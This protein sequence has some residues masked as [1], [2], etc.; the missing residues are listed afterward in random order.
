MEPSLT[1]HY[2]MLLGLDDSWKVSEVKLEM[3]VKRVAIRLEHAG[4]PL[5]CPE[6]GAACTRADLAPERTW[7]HLDTMQ[8]ETVLTARVP[9]SDCKACGVKTCAVPWA[10]KHSPFT[11]LF[12]VF[13]LSVIEASRCIEAARA[14]LRLSWDATHKIMKRGVERGLAHR[15]LSTVKR[16]GIDEKSFLRGQNYIASLC[17]LE[18]ARVIEVVQGRKEEDARRLLTSLP[19]ATRDRI[20]AIAM[21]MWP[22]FI[23]AAGKELP[24]AE[25]VFDRFHVSKHMGEAVDQVR[26]GE[27][28]ELLQ[29]GDKSLAK[30][31]YDW[32]RQEANIA[33]DRRKAFDA[34]K[35]S[36]LKTARAWAIKELLREFWE[37]RNAAFAELHFSKWYAWAVRC[38]LAA[39]KKVAKMLKKHLAGLLSYFR[40]RISNAAT[41]GFNSKIQAIKAAAR[42]FR[43]FENYRIRI[44][45]FCG[46]LNLRPQATH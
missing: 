3:E 15:D 38:R 24:Q 32:L 12:E 27:H 43:K 28:K 8:F 1:M 30:T 19:Q 34:L 29:T 40:H 44:L 35:A 37:S 39:V 41:E 4:G 5:A 22:A 36:G 11:W 14:V 21:D 7:R 31:R 13:A 16:V 45:F 18:E 26:R 25:I 33:E 10:G 17:D 6:C 46:R 20:E 23:I 9:R 42:G 2:A